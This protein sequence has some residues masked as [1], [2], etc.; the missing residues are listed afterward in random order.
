MLQVWCCILHSW[1]CFVLQA[2]GYLIFLPLVQWDT[3]TSSSHSVCSSFAS[4]SSS[5]WLEPTLFMPCKRMQ[6]LPRA[7]HLI[8][9]PP[10]D[11]SSWTGCSQ[12]YIF[13]IQQQISFFYHISQGAIISL[14]FLISILL[15]LLSSI[16]SMLL[17]EDLS[18]SGSGMRQAQ[19]PDKRGAQLTSQ[20]SSVWHETMS[21]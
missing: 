9:H 1:F 12:R 10:T 16:L 19:I 4:L 11:V 13:E 7:W 2:K 15:I 21:K 5:T 17:I 8:M 18:A 6:A 20:V 3:T 14:R